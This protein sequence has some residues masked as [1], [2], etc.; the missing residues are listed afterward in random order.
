MCMHKGSKNPFF[1][2]NGL[3][4]SPVVSIQDF[5]LSAD[6]EDVRERNHIPF[7]QLKNDLSAWDSGTA[8]PAVARG[9][10]TSISYAT[11]SNSPK[12][13]IPQPVGGEW[14]SI[15]VSS[16]VI[17]AALVGLVVAFRCRQGNPA[18]RIDKSKPIRGEFVK[19]NHS[20]NS[21][22]QLTQKTQH[23]TRIEGTEREAVRGLKHHQACEGHLY[24]DPGKLSSF[25]TASES[26][27]KKQL[28][29]QTRFE[30]I[31][32]NQEDSFETSLDRLPPPNGTKDQA[33]N[34]PFLS[35]GSPPDT[36][37]NPD[38]AIDS[39]QVEYQQ[40][41]PD[42][43]GSAGLKP[44][45]ASSNG[46]K[47]LKAP[48]SNHPKGKIFFRWFQGPVD[49]HRD[50]PGDEAKAP[51]ATDAEIDRFRLA[52]EDLG[53]LFGTSESQLQVLSSDPASALSAAKQS[54]DAD[55]NP[56]PR[57]ISLSVD[58]IIRHLQEANQALAA[59]LK[60]LHEYAS[61]L[62]AEKIELFEQRNAKTGEWEAFQKRAGSEIDEL[63]HVQSQLTEADDRN[64]HELT[65]LQ[66]QLAAT[67]QERE[68]AAKELIL[69]RQALSE[70][71]RQKPLTENRILELENRYQE[72]LSKNT[73]L[74]SEKTDLEQKLQDVQKN[75]SLTEN[76]ISQKSDQI[77][78]LVDQLDQVIR[79]SEALQR[80]KSQ[81]DIEKTVLVED[82]DTL[83]AQLTSIT[84][85]DEKW[86]W[87][88]DELKKPFVL[89][90]HS[91][92]ASDAERAAASQAID[93]LQSQKSELFEKCQSLNE[94]LERFERQNTELKRQNSELRRQG[95]E[96]HQNFSMLQGELQQ[97]RNLRSD[98]ERRMLQLEQASGAHAS[99]APLLPNQ[100]DSKKANAISS[101]SRPSNSSKV[102]PRELKARFTKL[103]RAFEREQEIR[104]NLEGFLE[105][106]EEQITRLQA[107]LRSF[108]ARR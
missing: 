81:W 41:S 58:P 96:S 56:P 57:P 107:A 61:K 89:L 43:V 2:L 8:E 100:R 12:G 80:Q 94:L 85:L 82:R 101:Q 92:V 3:M 28:V 17:L 52:E 13:S 42:R 53:S 102:I 62:E 9:A 47:P 50:R 103:Y 39:A 63:R 37:T 59:E 16:L 33:I 76:T 75:L 25:G 49:H 48:M 87:K 27:E 29:E 72:L 66:R 4:G 1:G 73:L 97:E 44:D 24:S 11:H 106:A 32:N 67:R 46:E 91:L 45:E 6:L 93:D 79:S 64:K 35:A 40:D 84:A 70:E 77:Q 78:Q 51:G 60:T 68:S 108:Q 15:F 86:K 55:L 19:R 74:L 22:F 10:T 65:A 30:T 104:K 90:Q 83:Q 14:M 69:L 71:K 18:N 98:I 31:S 95:S 34:G 99:L 20:T 88:H 36:A 26:D 23:D 54:P 21:K 7:S 105:Q 38:V 5:E